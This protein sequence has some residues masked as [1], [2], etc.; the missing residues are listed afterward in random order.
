M[1][2]AQGLE[3]ENSPTLPLLDWILL[4]SRVGRHLF[5]KK[6]RQ[7]DMAHFTV[8]HLPTFADSRGSLTVI[9]K[10]LPFNIVRLYWIYEVNGKTRGGHRHQKTTQAL[11]AV[12]GQVDVFMSDGVKEDTIILTRPNQ[13]LLVEP[14]DWHT[15]TFYNSSV[16]LVMAS[17]HFDENDYLDSPYELKKHD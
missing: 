17:H 7:Q 13:C 5:N 9:E 3:G 1:N 6:W 16:L 15:M 14:K 2:L 11:V 4:F 8:L 10:A 12:N